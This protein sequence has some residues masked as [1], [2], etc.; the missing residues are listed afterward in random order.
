[1]SRNWYSILIFSIILAPITL[2]NSD[3]IGISS[4]YL[5]FALVPILLKLKFIK[6]D[7]GLINFIYLIISYL[8][9][10]AFNLIYYGFGEQEI[11][12]QTVSVIASTLPLIFLFFNF[13][14]HK[15]NFENAVIICS[16]LYSSIVLAYFIVFWFFESGHAFMVKEYLGVHITDWPQ[17]Y[18]LVIFA[19]FYFSL[20][21]VNQKFYYKLLSVVFFLVIL[22]TYLR[23]AYLAIAISFIFYY[24]YSPRIG[25]LKIIMS[26]WK[27]VFILIILALA[28][29]LEGS[30]GSIFEY[31][32]ATFNALFSD[33]STPASDAT[34]LNIWI[35][36]LEV[37]KV[38]PITGN[39]GGGIYLYDPE[40]GSYHNQFID[41]LTRF[42]IVGLVI[43]F[44]Y[45]Y[46]IFKNPNIT[47]A[48]SAILIAYLVFGLVHETIKLS[49]GAVIFYFLLS[50]SYS[51]KYK[52]TV[53]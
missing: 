37:L 7:D 28:I 2:E 8:I 5:F 45:N 26:H 36:A 16:T 44:Y 14:N 41:I 48:I 53:N 34:R 32:M 15:G 33:G 51:D 6:N 43:H 10:V 21:R 35:S 22:L 24:L 31:F 23:A 40:F 11:I 30:V 50:L 46:R 4:N 18:V 52:E 27:S 9:G 12:R 42:G 1:M 39:G 19:G 38:N 3:G 29:F 20:S 17:R 25:V 13:K 49:Y 47:P